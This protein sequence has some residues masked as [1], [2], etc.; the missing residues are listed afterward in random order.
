MASFESS[1]NLI[2]IV[3]KRRSIKYL[4]FTNSELKF[5][6][7]VSFSSNLLLSTSSFVLIV[8]KEI[9][10]ILPL[11]PRTRIPERYVRARIS[12]SAVTREAFAVVVS[13][14][15]TMRTINSRG[16]IRLTESFI[17]LEKRSFFRSITEGSIK[18]VFL[19]IPADVLWGRL[20]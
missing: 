12:P 5:N 20:L 9:S 7:P 6:L 14:R 3:K 1:E 8:F 19:K 4:L 13:W 10:S 18:E 15:F 17:E 2:I 11:R 16:E